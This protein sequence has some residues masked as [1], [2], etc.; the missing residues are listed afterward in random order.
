LSACH[1][2]ILDVLSPPACASCDTP[3]GTSRLL[4]AAC[5]DPPAPLLGELDD[6]VLVLAS[7]R[8]AGGVARAITRFKYASRPDLAPL[9]AERLFD[10]VNTANL[11]GPCLF[12]PVP[13]HPQRLARRGYNQS[14]L[15]SARLARLFGWPVRPRALARTV[16]TIAQASLSREQRL[17][18]VAHAIVA[19]EEIESAHVA[20]V[21]DVVTTGATALACVR[22][23]MAA[24]AARVTILAVARATM[25]PAV[26]GH[27]VTGC[28]ERDEVARQGTSQ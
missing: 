23:L 28:S 27:S 21:D 3:L 14:A 25:E 7:G 11:R 22:A 13:L 8:Y 17:H 6:G 16:D 26:T 9:L 12:V 18:N 1:A 5:D 15:L 24:G 20:L 2:A 10:A 19:R 4:C